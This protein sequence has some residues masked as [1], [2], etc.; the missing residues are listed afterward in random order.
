MK[1][2]VNNYISEAAN[3]ISDILKNGNGCYLVGGC[4]LGKSYYI[5]NILMKDYTCLNV[6]FLNVLNLQNFSETYRE[7][8]SSLVDYKGEESISIN[9]QNLEYVSDEAIE[10]IDI[11]V[12]DE[13]QNLWFSATYR[14]CSGDKLVNQLKRF[15]EAG[16]KILI[17]TGT[18]IGGATLGKDLGLE[19][20]EVV[21]KNIE[22]KDR[23]EFTFKGG[24]NYTNIAS[25]V[26]SQLKL[27]KTVVVL[28]DLHRKHIRK[29]LLDN[30]IVFREIQSDDKTIKDTATKY[31]IDNQRL[32]EDC[33]VFLSTSIL[34]GGVN[35]LEEK[36]E[37]EIVYITFIKDISNPMEAIQF[38]GRSRNQKK[39]LVIGYDTEADFNIKFNHILFDNRETDILKSNV[40]QEMEDLLG[41]N[42]N[43]EEDW[44]GYIQR[45]CNSEIIR[46]EGKSNI[47]NIKVTETDWRKF[48]KVI[49]ANK[50]EGKSS[51][52]YFKVKTETDNDLEII[53][54][55]NGK[56]LN[57]WIFVSNVSKARNILRVIDLGFDITKMDDEKIDRLLQIIYTAKMFIYL[58][59]NDNYK[60]IRKDIILDKVDFTMETFKKRFM[61]IFKVSKS[62]NG[63][64]EE[65]KEWEKSARV[66]LPL[67]VF[68]NYRDTVISII[69]KLAHESIFLLYN[70]NI[71]PNLLG[72]GYTEYF[73]FDDEIVEEAIKEKKNDI[74]TKR[75]IAASKKIKVLKDNHKRLKGLLNKEFDSVNDAANELGVNRKTISRMIKE[76]LLG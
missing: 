70:N 18:P 48:A 11:L 7:G 2:N 12:I 37:R 46:I 6:N 74:S 29:T 72:L 39:V 8:K 56:G 14:L 34:A 28:S 36:D 33:D 53:D 66:S 63:K 22:E 3:E 69:R 75:S 55:P 57:K 35:L 42:L 54:N 9:V 1:I 26:D 20:V 25:E 4:G 68:T 59:D 31:I 43:S 30:Q 44:F 23:Y 13:I 41:N 76:G 60:D 27:G 47:K 15:S 49:E 50:K 71:N 21:K 67:F 40:V 10:N 24:L 32:P 16:V 5:K 65:L 73:E 38:S 62:V 52:E 58:S 51:Y 45:F 17:L 64:V 19:S 61:E